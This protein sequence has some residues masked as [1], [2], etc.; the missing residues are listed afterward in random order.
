VDRAQ[1]STSLVE[2]LGLTRPPVALAFADAQ[3]SGV[4][5]PANA[6]PSTCSFWRRAEEKVFYAS[7]EDHFNCLLGS[8]V[9]GFELP[10]EASQEL[11]GLV[12]FMCGEYYIGKDEPAGIPTV[13]RKSAGILYGPLAELPA[14]PDLI[15]MWLT[16][17][18]AMIFNEAIGGSDWAGE[19]MQV[20]G[21]PGCAALPRALQ[22]H[23]PSVSL[24]CTGLRTFT[25]IGNEE[26]LAVVPGD[27]G[28]EVV[29]ALERTV[30]ANAAMSAFYQ[31]QLAKLR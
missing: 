2:L 27:Q 24:G 26:L 21:R 30:N 23:K 12:E 4:S 3:P 19:L 18:Q 11:G 15:I 22:G 16:P 5:R 10:A 20:S 13:E 9:M 7:A 6:A 14:E 25:Q 17:H 1:T 28:E 29:A 8:M 31:Q